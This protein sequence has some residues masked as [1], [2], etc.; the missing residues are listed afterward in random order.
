MPLDEVNFLGLSWAVLI[1]FSAGFPPN[2]RRDPS[3]VFEGANSTKQES[4][5]DS[6]LAVMI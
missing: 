1:R 2:I 5:D 6:L 4:T 3:T